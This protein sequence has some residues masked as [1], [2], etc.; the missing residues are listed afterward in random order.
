MKVLFIGFC[1]SS[2]EYVMVVLLIGHCDYIGLYGFIIPDVIVHFK[3]AMRDK[4]LSD[5]NYS[6]KMPFANK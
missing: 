3:P 4:A 6:L 2:D 1:I 5:I